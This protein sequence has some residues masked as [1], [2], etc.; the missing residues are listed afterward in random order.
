[1]TLHEA[2]EIKAF[3]GKYGCNKRMKTNLSKETAAINEVSFH[4]K[5]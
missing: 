2:G 4:V 3:T 1:M 5:P